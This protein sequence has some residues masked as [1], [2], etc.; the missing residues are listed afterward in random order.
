MSYSLPV[1]AAIVFLML[2]VGVSYRQTIR[3]YPQGGGSYIVASE[4]LGRVP[5]LMAAAGLLIDY[6]MTVAVSITSSVGAITSAFP[7]MQPT[8]VSIGV[9]V[10]VIL[11][12][13]NL[14]GVRRAGAMFAV[15]T[16]AFIAAAIAALV[17]AGLVHAAGSW[18]PAHPG[19][20]PGH[21]AGRYHAAGAARVHRQLPRP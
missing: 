9:G 16:Y 10:I 4:E 1:G 17:V 18:A 2:A 8:T 21:R 12:T 7:S 15:P 3:A 19:S 13:G 11:L 6:I 5:G 14:R 20:P